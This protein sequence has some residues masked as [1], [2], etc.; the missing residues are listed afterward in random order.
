MRTLPFCLILAALAGTACSDALPTVESE[1]VVSSTEGPVAGPDVG[2]GPTIVR[3]AASEGPVAT[4]QRGPT[5]TEGPVLVRGPDGT[6]PGWPVAGG[7]LQRAASAGGDPASASG[8]ASLTSLFWEN[9]TTGQRYMWILNGE[10]LVEDASLSWVATRWTMDASADLSGDGIPDILWTNRSTGLRYV[11]FMEGTTDTGGASLG[12]V[13]PD[14]TIDGVGDFNGDLESDILWTDTRTGERYVWF[15][16]GTTNVGGS[17]L[18]IIGSHWEM[19]AVADLNADGHVDILITNT[20]NGQRWVWEMSGTTVTAQ[21]SLGTV[22]THWEIV[23]ARD[24]NGDGNADILWQNANTGVRYIWYMQGLTNTGGNVLVENSPSWDIAAVSIDRVGAVTITTSSLPDGS[25]GSAYSQTLTA[26]GG[27]GSYTWSLTAGSLPPGLSLGA[28]T[29][30]ISGTPTTTG[31]SN[32]TVQA[33]SGSW[34]ATKALSITVTQACTLS[35]TPDTDG[36]RLPDCAETGTGVYVS[37]TNTGTDPNDSDTDDDGIGDGDEVRGTEGG[38]DL[39]GMG[40]SPLRKNLLVEFDAY[41]HNLHDHALRVP[42]QQALT[43]AFQ[44]A[45]VSNPDG[46]TGIDLIMD[47]GQGGAFTGGGFVT[48]AGGDGCLAGGVDGA[49]YAAH[50]Q[51]DFAANRAGYFHY[52]LM[53]HQWGAT[54]SGSCAGASSGSGQAFL[55]DHRAVVAT[56]SWYRTESWVANTVL[57]MLGHNLNLGHGGPVSGAQ[58]ALNYKPNYNSVM[59]E[60]YQFHG[61][62]SGCDVTADGGTALSTGTRIALDESSVSEPDGVCGPGNPVDWNQDSDAVDTG[63]SLD[64]QAWDV[65]DGVGVGNGSS[66]DLLQDYNDWANILLASSLAVGGSPTASTCTVVAPT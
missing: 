23:G 45:P 20:L 50:V 28:S 4:G 52:V 5:A 34:T 36:D 21:T 57:H 31:T 46:S 32:F 60:R 9:M 33:A 44:N 43:A 55:D 62:D 19:V 29:G 51:N 11:W 14:W 63:L 2:P 35:S 42:T 37:P 7:P 24:F 17:S 66:S 65:G 30:T 10:S 59:N 15:M 64:L 3:A 61:T 47:R 54:A 49:E 8:Y 6:A 16:N 13:A 12:E 1:V 41:A 39:P 27:T 22:P 53:V 48:D 25:V 38:L 40:V 18:G 58:A 56:G 26:T